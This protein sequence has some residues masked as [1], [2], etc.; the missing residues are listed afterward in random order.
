MLCPAKA[1]TIPADIAQYYGYMLRATQKLMYLYGFPQIDVEENCR[2]FDSE[3]LNLLIRCMGAMYGVV[4]ASN[5]LKAV[6]NGRCHSG[7]VCRCDYQ[8]V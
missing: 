6:D 2:D 3:T 1:A 4:G 8:W 5:A 7:R